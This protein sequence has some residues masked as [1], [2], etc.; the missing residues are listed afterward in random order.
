M[1]EAEFISLVGAIYDAAAGTSK[2]PDAL[3]QLAAIY[4]AQMAGFASYSPNP[5]ECWGVMGPDNPD[6]TREYLTYYH[7]KNILLERTLHEPAGALHTDTMVMPKRAFRRTEFYNDF[8]SRHGIHAMSHLVVTN[9]DGRISE[10]AIHRRQDFDRADLRVLGRLYPHLRRAFDFS[11][12]LNH[13]DLY[14]AAAFEALERL[15]R[16][17]LLVDAA[18]RVLFANRPAEQ[19][20]HDGA[21]LRLHAGSLSAEVAAEAARLRRAI[22]QCHAP[23]STEPATLPISRGS[24]RAPLSVSI[25]PVRSSGPLAMPTAVRAMVLIIDPEQSKKPPAELLRQRFGL[26][27]AEAALALEIVRGEGVQAA[28]DRLHV[29]Q[30]TARTHLVR[31]FSK[32]GTRRQAE[33]VRL[34]LDLT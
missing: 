14:Q 21:G 29:S 25:V 1:T 15:D 24:A 26:T 32:T 9:T 34:L 27:R 31:V 19:L 12:R 20:F 11:V 4:N 2:W 22:G 30:S 28:A 10:V 6:L 5:A 3:L 33:L 16:A 13:A 7:T 23:D 8:L 18:A 17:A